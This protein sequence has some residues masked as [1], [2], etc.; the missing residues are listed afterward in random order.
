MSKLR[1]TMMGML[2]AA[3]VLSSA[4]CKKEEEKEPEGRSKVI[5]YPVSD[6]ER[7][8]AAEALQEVWDDPEVRRR[9]GALKPTAETKGFC[10]DLVVLTRHPHR[11]AGY[12]SFEEISLDGGQFRVYKDEPGSLAAG[13][14][15]ANRLRAMGVEKVLTQHFSVAQ[16]VPTDCRISVD[17]KTYTQADGV[18]PM[19]PNHLQA[20]VTPAEGLTGQT[21][22]AGSG[23]MEE[24]KGDVLGR[25]V[26]LDYSAGNRW[27]P[28]FALGAKA[29]IFIG[30]DEPA[31][32]PYH[33]INTPANL[34]RFYVTR[35]LAEKLQLR[36]ES[37]TVTLHA[38]AEWRRL[39]GQNVIGIIP[40]REARFKDSK[41]KLKD[42][43]EALLLAVPLDSLSEVPML[44]PGARGAANCAALL[45]LAEKFQRTPPRRDI[46]LAFLDGDAC[47]HEGAR[48]LYGSLYRS[49]AVKPKPSKIAKRL[50]MFHEE[51]QY[52]GTANADE[53]EDDYRGSIREILDLGD[54]LVTAAKGLGEIVA[55]PDATLTQEAF[56]QSYTN[57]WKRG[58]KFIADA[59]ALKKKYDKAGEN[60]LEKGYANTI[61]F[62]KAEAK[63]LSGQIKDDL[64]LRRSK[65]NHY[66]DL[67]K[68]LTAKR[69]KLQAAAIKPTA[70]GT[71][72]TAPAGIAEIDKGIE[73]CRIALIDLI[74]E[75]AELEAIDQVAWG[76]VERSLN[77]DEFL[78]KLTPKKIDEN[79]S[80]GI[81]SYVKIIRKA[82]RISDETKDE[83]IRQV[84]A[85]RQQLGREITARAIKNYVSLLDSTKRVCDKRQEELSR[86]IRHTQEGMQV[87][88]AIGE[89]K[90]AIVL[91]LSMNLGDEADRWTF[92]HGNDSRDIHNGKD[93]AGA[94]AS[95]VF[96]AI[97]NV[98][99]KLGIGDK[100]SLFDVSTV[101]GSG[102]ARRLASGRF[103]HSGSVAGMFGIFNLSV[104]TPLGRRVRDG[105]PCD[106]VTRRDGQGA[107][108]AVLNVAD[109]L[110]PQQQ[111][112]QT[113]RAL[114]DTKRLSIG[115]GIDSQAFYTEFKY[116]D[117]RYTGGRVQMLSGASAAP[118]RPARGAF[119]AILRRPGKIWEGARVDK[120]PAG[121]RP[122]CII[123]TDVSGRIEVPPLS[124]A[125]YG[126]K[127][128]VGALFDDRGLIDFVSSQA[129]ALLQ[130]ALFE[131][132]NILFRTIGITVVGYG[133]DRGATST[134]A[135]KAESTAPLN[136]GRSLVAENRNVL[137]VYAR[138]PTY[139]LK[140]FNP[141]GMIVLGNT[142]ED[143]E[144]MDV[145]V[146]VGLEIDPFEHWP[147]YTITPADLGALDNSR[148]E[149]L[150]KHRIVER[151]LERL[152]VE[153]MDIRDKA[154]QLPV[155][156]VQYRA[157]RYAGAAA[158]QRSIYKPIKGVLNDLVVAVVLLLLL[159]I[160]FAYSLER[161]L[162]G[163]P[164]I[165][166][167]IGWFAFF[168]LLTFTLLFIVNPAFRIA[169]TPIIIFLAFAIIL[170]SLLVIVIMTRK[171][172]AEVGRMQGLA[173]SVHSSD[174]SR[175][176]TM[177][178]AV[179]M[180]I[181]TMRRRPVRTVLTATT[182]VLLTFTILTF[183]SFTSSWGPRRTY[184]GP[185]IGPPRLLVR[186]PLWSRLEESVGERLAAFFK[187]EAVVVPR[188]W[189]SQ[190]AGEVQAYKNANRTKEI[191][192]ADG[193]RREVKPISALMGIDYRD[194]ELMPGLR[195]LF[196]GDVEMLKEGR[197]GVFITP[198]LAGPNGINVQVGDE[199][200]VDGQ[201]CILA[202][203]IVSKKIQ[204][205]R[206]LEGTQMLP[207]DYQ[208][209]GGGD[210]QGFQAQESMALDDL[211]EMESAQFVRFDRDM[212]AIISADLAR[213]LDGRV[214]SISIYPKEQ[215]DLEKMGDRVA[216]ITRLPTYVGGQGGVYRL[217]FTSLTEAS[218]WRDLLIPVV[219]G[220]LIIFATMLGSVSDRE[221]EI[222]AFSALGLAP[223]H[224]ASLFF[225]EA[226]V[227]AVV[228]GMG[229]YLLGQ[230]IAS[231]L[232]WV[233]EGFG[234]YSI[235]TMNYSSM[236]AIATVMVVMATV[237]ISTI[238]PA[239]KASRSANPGI[240]RSWKIPKPDVDLYDLVFPFTVSAYDIT[241][242]VSFLREHFRNFS[243]TALGVFATS[244][245][246]AFRSSE[247][248]L[249]LQAEVALA[250][251]DLG[252]SQKFALMAQPSE[253]EG[254]EEIRILLH[255]VS[256]TR[257]DWQRANRVFINELRKQLLIWRSLS[258]EIMEKYR[259]MTLQEWKDLPV[260]DIQPETFGGARDE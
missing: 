148:L 170:L 111:I 119:V 209:S 154:D 132:S 76:L 167:Q 77:K 187:A 58:D 139:R 203:L 248:M 135:L 238:Y 144:D 106:V 16:G 65:K 115:S 84:E 22:W 255:R 48:A 252:V 205:Y 197:R 231:G 109:M 128:I 138:N 71:A 257:G 31:A 38:A 14:Y 150:K 147:V 194:I 245:V 247:D 160:P 141:E 95:G 113:I 173:T 215:V 5:A 169:A 230:V 221:K 254:I 114:A 9:V 74:I 246:S 211:P 260:E 188:Y 207:V 129:S 102:T 192:L 206:M 57:A 42:K 64:Y 124:Q 50:A 108:V 25:I 212:V 82:P 41:G 229:G 2:A 184:Q 162:I 51:R 55:K 161:L 52:I 172:Q 204:M 232:T 258:S 104:M 103:A 19:R 127:L 96:R 6:A 81:E 17:G 190:T 33:H 86:L 133:Y 186:H 7:T 79:I 118:D 222:Y 193:H 80:E 107:E 153:A 37:R 165:Y 83:L 27:L 72:E 98:A 89:E 36:Q 91:H 94:Y 47:N 220:G 159:A 143:V 181:S 218:G 202:G 201:P 93:N 183:A 199:V 87:I 223:P 59:K 250:P 26:V 88:S 99:D 73:Q 30:S 256:G 235:P 70:G 234:I 166:R 171:L 176:G 67:V 259:Q 11:L 145:T 100:N 213:S 249:G 23:K 63:A 29:V 35:E 216:T 224:V 152:H 56:L 28:A 130:K 49:K 158:I 4:G 180:G 163:T 134:L 200:L 191:T 177:M 142:Y 32:N 69:K 20:V 219:L 175:L 122:Y 156:D 62:L 164:H 179:H 39:E 18:Y 13:Y 185:L 168:F 40:G 227:Y 210:A 137:S 120:T 239:I 21:L 60:D 237:L 43:Q 214:A 125:Y 126:P 140:L 97:R 75:I 149:L 225:A 196:D 61:R 189:V 146:G 116:D 112:G 228:G 44:S 157:G 1:L 110:A 178:A 54:P 105:Q 182:V 24:Y 136:A 8:K 46:I 155:E 15:V 68:H 121:F 92:I 10:R 123:E 131:T 241:G 85:R 90:T 174:V 251:F 198:T 253:I 195:E 117:G 242:V 226:G 233:A 236:N 53:G 151:S 78:E 240:Q 12:G 101:E 45:A 3:L 243:D 208:A 34:P 66:E 217:L 244:S